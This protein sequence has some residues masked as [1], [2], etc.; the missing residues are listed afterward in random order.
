MDMVG[1]LLLRAS[2]VFEGVFTRLPFLE[3]SFKFVVGD[4]AIGLEVR[5]D[6]VGFQSRTRS[7]RH[8]VRLRRHPQTLSQGCRAFAPRDSSKCTTQLM[9]GQAQPN[10]GRLELRD[11]LIDQ[12]LCAVVSKERNSLLPDLLCVLEGGDA[13]RAGSDGALIP[14]SEKR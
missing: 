7:I 13:Q 5:H 3:E 4:L 2:A 12:R 9:D 6:F 10:G 14:P 11:N 1:D 8:S